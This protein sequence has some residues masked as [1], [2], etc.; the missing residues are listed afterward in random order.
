MAD[1]FISSAGPLGT[2]DGNSEANAWSLANALAGATAGDYVWI[3]NDGVYYGIFT[4]G[5]TGSYADNTHIYFIG[6][7]NIANCDLV[8]HISDMDMGQTFW[9]G[10]MNPTAS[11]CWVD[12]DGQGAT[13]HVVYQYQKNNVHWRNIHFHNN[14]KT[15]NYSA[16]YVKYCSGVTF[17]KCKFT[18]GYINLWVDTNST[19]CMIKYCYFSDY[20]ATNLDIGGGSY[21]NIYS[22]CVFN[23][24]HAKMYRSVGCNSIFIG[25]NYGIGAY[26]YQN[27]VFNNT[28]YGQTS[29]CLCYG[30]NSYAGGLI[31]YNNIFIPAAK[32]IPAIYRNGSG[33][34]AYSG[35][36]CAY[37]VADDSVLDTPYSGEDGLNVNPQFVNAAA[38][39]FRVLNPL[40][41]RGG[42]PDFTGR[43]TQIGA[44]LQ[45]YQFTKRSAA[46]NPARMSIFK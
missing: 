4:V 16:F 40:L 29:Y 18:D 11:N 24:G 39:D 33:S 17:S 31:E 28:M 1:K 8:N 14:S 19:S 9:G 46:G 37:S 10:P 12:I 13:N 38:N 43:Q 30:H 44:V 23:G 6:Y 5:C 20:G 15:A 36:G 21:L 35:C 25:G 42:M 45:Q 2:G 32:N 34:L 3:K 41:L 27:I 26:Y 22:H 7:N